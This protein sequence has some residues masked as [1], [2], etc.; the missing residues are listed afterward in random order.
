M[1]KVIPKEGLAV[2]YQSFFWYDNGKYLYRLCM[3]SRDTAELIFRLMWMY[4]YSRCE[5]LQIDII[6]DGFRSQGLLG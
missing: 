3:F 6:C 4:C 2:P 5:T 1:V